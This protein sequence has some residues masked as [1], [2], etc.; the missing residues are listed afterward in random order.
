MQARW[1]WNDGGRNEFDEEQSWQCSLDN[2]NVVRRSE[3]TNTQPASEGP[4]GTLQICLGTGVASHSNA[5]R[6][7]NEGSLGGGYISGGDR[8]NAGMRP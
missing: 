6:Q 8:T 2:R 5:F 4:N 7:S 1:K 3:G